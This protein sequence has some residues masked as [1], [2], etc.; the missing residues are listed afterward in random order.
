MTGDGL[1]L[2]S[3]MLVLFTK[4]PTADDVGTTGETL[5]PGGTDVP[6]DVLNAGV[7]M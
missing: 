2:V 5:R 4:G 1:K 3:E 7:E 6:N